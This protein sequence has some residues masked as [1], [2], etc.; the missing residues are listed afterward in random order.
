MTE[1]AWSGSIYIDGSWVAGAA[2]DAPVIE[3][4]TGREI[5]RT[6]RA[7]VDDVGRAAS[8]AAVAQREWAALPHT[9]RAEVLRRAGDLFG[10]HSDE[11]AR[12]NIREVGAVPGMAGFALHVAAEECYTSS[13]LP[14]APYGQLIPSEEPRFSFS[15]RVPAGV[16][17]VISPFNV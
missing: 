5:G 16:V 14:G 12:W 1:P 15:E 10:E 3:P 17:G 7:G 9:K 2:G 4:A 11:F 6:G 8:S 13:G